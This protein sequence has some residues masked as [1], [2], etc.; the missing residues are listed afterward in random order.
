M[1]LSKKFKCVNK[2]LGIIKLITWSMVHLIGMWWP[3]YLTL[4][5]AL[6]AAF[7]LSLAASTLYFFMQALLEGPGYVPQGWKPVSY[8]TFI[9]AE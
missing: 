6:H 7:F 8:F 5:G 3:P 2:S 4:G 9:E 1:N